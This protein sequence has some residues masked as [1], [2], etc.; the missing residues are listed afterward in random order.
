MGEKI[1]ILK[2]ASREERRFSCVF[3]LAMFGLGKRCCSQLLRR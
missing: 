2:S 3:I 1:V